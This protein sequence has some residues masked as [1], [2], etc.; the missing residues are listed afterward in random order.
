MVLAGTHAPRGSAQSAAY[1][2]TNLASDVN[3]P[4]FADH[5]DLSLQDSWGLT[6]LPGF[7]FF[8]ANPSNGRVTAL[9]AD[10]A[11]Q[12]PGAFT[13]TNPTGAGAGRPTA[14]VAD[15]QG[16]FGQ[17]D[18]LHSFVKT[19]VIVSSD[20][21]IYVWGPDVNG[22]LPAAATLVV[23]H[24][25]S[26][27]S[28]TGITIVQP[29]CCGAPLLAV[30]N[31][32]DG[33]IE[34]Y[35]ASFARLA[36]GSFTDPDLP[37]DYAPFG[38]Q[39]IGKQVFVTYALQT[40]PA[41]PPI[42][43]PGN[44][45]VSIFDLEGNFL[46][47]FATGGVL[48]APWGVAQAGASF[49]PFSNDILIGNAGDGAINAFDSTTG[50]FA[51]SVKDGG[52]NVLANFGLHGLFFG[53]Q[54]S[55]GPN[56]LFFAAGIDNGRN[57]L[58]GAITTGLVTTTH[59]FAPTATI[60]TNFRLA[61][62]V[63]PAAGNAGNPTGEV[64]FR[65]GRAAL[66][67]AV[68]VNGS[69]EVEIAL[70]STGTHNLVAEYSGDG[71]FLASADTVE[72]QVTAFPATVELTAPASAAPGSAVT[73][74][75][76]V[77]SSDGLPTG[78]VGFND[79]QTTL[80]SATLDATGVAVLRT[81]ALTAGT[82]SLTASYAGDGK[83]A[84]ST[85]VAVTVSIAS[86]DFSLSANPPSATIVA[87]QPAPFQ[88]TVTP[89][90]GFAGNVTFSCSA[91]AGLSCAFNPTSV[92][93][94]GGAK[95]ATLTVATSSRIGNFG[96][97]ILRPVQPIIFPVGSVL[98]LLML[99]KHSK[100]GASLARPAYLFGLAMLLFSLSV[101]GCGGSAAPPNQRTA[102]ITVTAQSGSIAHTTTLQV[103]LQ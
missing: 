13:V 92:T 81:D 58:F 73:L 56:S 41:R 86:P 57:G 22:N 77:S 64:T 76:T 16:L 14:I 5:I 35:T 10:G 69:A 36:P 42:V 60:D 68:L 101:A 48:N 33:T 70:S 98:L 102:S 62:S 38:I 18:A 90:G 55:G 28:Y 67:N 94:A 103:T 20:G 97:P 71:T 37:A 9:D 78:Q 87:S 49:G 53:S 89:S 39:A 27:A 79:G 75:A 54:Q 93:L 43:G 34:P 40:D 3:T 31:F 44:G 84:A 21:G 100:M 17:I 11:S 52:E 24:S 88:L 85:S 8:V 96:L 91:T 46:K 2:Q 65:E 26:H 74:S 1:R 83:F 99:R 61:A 51:G 19:I 29:D 7:S 47:R 59:A 6:F 23:D 30:V 66:G 45:I 50:D 82:H 80:G 4:G 32:H 72:V 63:V 15:P 12:R 95:A 25:A